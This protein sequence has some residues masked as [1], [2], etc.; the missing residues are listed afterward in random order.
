MIRSKK[1]LSKYTQK[2]FQTAFFNDKKIFKLKQ[3]YNSHNDVLH[4]LKK[5]GKV[6]LPKERLFYENEAFFKQI[7]VSVVVWKAFKTSI[8]FV[9]PN[10]KVNAKYYCNVLLK[11]IIPEMNRL[12]KHN[13]YSCKTKLELTQLSSLLKCWK[14]RSNFD[15]WSPITGHRFV[16]IWIQ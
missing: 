11:K 1:L 14:T 2:T 8:F 9:Q 13:E 4:V 16:Q 10:K 12:A 5:M 6:E 7:M 15:Y 3:L